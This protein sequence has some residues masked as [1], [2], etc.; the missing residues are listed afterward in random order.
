MFRSSDPMRPRSDAE[1]AGATHT[2]DTDPAAPR[3]RLSGDPAP[4]T[5]PQTPTA[6]PGGG[7]LT[8]IAAIA[9][10]IAAIVAIP[11]GGIMVFIGGLIVGAAL[12]IF[13]GGSGLRAA[14]LSRRGRARDASATDKVAEGLKSEF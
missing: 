14:V 11:F 3:A 8:G 9:V 6:K 12:L 13:G 2:P 5:Q 10:L 1:R 4:G 7:L